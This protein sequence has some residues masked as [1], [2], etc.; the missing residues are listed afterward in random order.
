[1]ENLAV[2]SSGSPFGSA[3]RGKRVLVTGHT[4]FKGAWLS[5]WLLAL[6]AR[7]TGLALCP[8]TTPALFDQLDLTNRLTD[9]RCDVRDL[10]AVEAIVDRVRPDFVFHLAAQPLVRLSYAQPAETYATNVMGT[11][12]V[13]EAIRRAKFPCIVIA[14]TTD[15]CYENREWLNSYREMDPLG[16][17]D[18]YSSS[19]GAAEL[20]IEAYRRSYFSASDSL[21]R[22][23]SARA[24]NVI[25]GGDW[26]V[27][28]IVPD[29]I[30]ALS[31]GEAI[32]VRNQTAMRPWQHVLE[33]LS[34]YLWLAACLAD[35]SAQERVSLRSA[36]LWNPQAERIKALC[37]AFNFGPALA[38][39]RCVL[40]VVEEIL[41]HWPGRWEDRSDPKAVHEAKLLSLATDKAHHLLG[42]SPV[43]NFEQT[44]ARTTL[45]YR[46]AVAASDVIPELT[47][48]QI[49]AYTA[50]AGA[51]GLRWSGRREVAAR[52]A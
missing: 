50:D 24:G 16:G 37:S 26:A 15:K 39:N 22:L 18:P 31:R 29:C 11:V 1:M 33:P 17:H 41:R 7:V 19:K 8:P 48:Q 40:N 42:W 14:I 47:R 21:V 5:E 10:A 32:P 20:V 30:R 36:E 12:N 3:Y 45:W 23:A 6:G 43:W 34:G 44:I 4:G 9:L 28:R 25:G 49:D 52:V 13:L 27:D 2:T 35:A 46:Q 38:S 51:I